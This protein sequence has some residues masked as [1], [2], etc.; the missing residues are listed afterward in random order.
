MER[1]KKSNPIYFF[2]II[3]VVLAIIFYTLTDTEVKEAFFKENKDSPIENKA[4]F[5]GLSYFDPLPEYRLLADLERL[6]GNDSLTIRMS[7]GKKETLAK[8]AYATFQLKGKA[9]RLLLLKHAEEES[10]FLPFGDKTNGLET[11][12]GGRYLD[13]K[14]E[15]GNPDKIMIDFNL[16]YNPFCA[17]NKNYS[18]P[19]PPYEN[20]LYVEI[21]AGEKEYIPAEKK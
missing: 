19:L 4:A 5:N 16:A 9:H 17:Y 12:G 3:L 10:L 18:C 21:K 2:G 20:Q 11:Y 14:L 1:K 6:K 15:K 7:D 8:Y 13:L